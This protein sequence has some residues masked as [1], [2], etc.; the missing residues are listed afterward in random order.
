MI[1]IYDPVGGTEADGVRYAERLVNM[2]NETVSWENFTAS[3]YSEDINMIDIFVPLLT[4]LLARVTVNS[5]WLFLIFGLV[6]GFFYSRNIWFVLEKLPGKLCFSLVGLITCYML[7]CPIW[8]INAV[9]MWTALHIF[10]YGA[11]P[12][13]YNSD[14][15]KLFWCVLSVFVHFSYVLPLIILIIYYFIPK[16]TTV[17][18]C[19]YLITFFIETINLEQINTVLTSLLPNFL[20]SRVNMY[21]NENVLQSLQ[22]AQNST[23]F[24]ILLS[25]QIIK[26]GI[27]IAFFAICFY[28][29]KWIK[30][31]QSLYNIVCFSLFTYTIFNIVSLVPQGVRFIQIS[32]MFSFISII[33]FFA[34]IPNKYKSTNI[35][36]IFNGIS[37]ALLAPIIFFLRRGC[38]YY[39]ISLFFNPI[40]TLFIDD[41]QP[42]IQFVKSIFN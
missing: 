37:I 35:R 9:R 29:K 28:G 1:H 27:A 15:S 16:S 39:G 14:R 4:Y 40:A 34:L 10:I 3:F 8:E 19:I 5:S 25:N 17:L 13:L 36:L 11:L 22:E 30:N 7:L 42:I 20:F 2:H 31:S 6:F 41:N 18:Y 38:D 32:N 26:W 23:N 24:Y 12:Y 21:V 33:L